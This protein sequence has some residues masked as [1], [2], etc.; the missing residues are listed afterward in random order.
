MNKLML[1]IALILSLIIAPGIGTAKSSSDLSATDNDY[2][3]EMISK[4]QKK[5]R[6]N[7][8]EFAHRLKLCNG[9]SE[10]KFHYHVMLDICFLDIFARCD[11]GI[12]DF[13]T[14]WSELVIDIDDYEDYAVYLGDGKIYDD[15]VEQCFVGEKDCESLSEFQE[16]IKAYM[17]N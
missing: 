15:K 7:A 17:K 4:M 14:F 13:N 9:K 2:D 3:K 12:G 11:K 8:V 16:L 5:C 1:A 10:Y 6:K